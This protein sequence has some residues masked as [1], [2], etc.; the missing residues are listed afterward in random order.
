MWFLFDHDD[1]VTRR[2]AAASGISF[3]TQ[4]NV[5]SLTHSSRNRN[6][7]QTFPFYAPFA[8][9]RGA[10]ILDDLPLAVTAVAGADVHELPE[11]GP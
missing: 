8:A 2:S 1:D 10:A 5:I 11:H 4:R 7:D 6:L 9:A 3:A